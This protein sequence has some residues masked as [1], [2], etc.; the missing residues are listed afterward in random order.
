MIA[1]S[2]SWQRWRSIDIYTYIVYDIKIC[3]L[4]Y[5]EQLTKRSLTL[6]KL[7]LLIGV[8]QPILAGIIL[9]TFVIWYMLLIPMLVLVRFLSSW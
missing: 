9:R 3:H 2:S 7:S 8:R 6:A 4:N 5:W 1:A